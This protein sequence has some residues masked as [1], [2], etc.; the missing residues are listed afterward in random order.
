MI[1]FMKLDLHILNTPALLL[2]GV[3]ISVSQQ[4]RARSELRNVVMLA[5]FESVKLKKTDCTCFVLP[6]DE[7]ILI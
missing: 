7:L 5:I 2:F 3:K 4:N 1:N 6:C